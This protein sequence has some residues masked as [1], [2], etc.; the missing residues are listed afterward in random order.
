MNKKLKGWEKN[1]VLTNAKRC[2]QIKQS[3][4]KAKAEL[5]E[6]I[7]KAQSRYEEK[8]RNN[9]KV[10]AYDSYLDLI[11]RITRNPEIT[12]DDIYDVEKTDAVIMGNECKKTEYKLKDSFI[13]QYLTAEEAEKTETETTEET[14]EN[15]I[16]DQTETEEN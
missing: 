8:M 6:Q 12:P 16:F 7:K 5:D 2:L 13:A 1:Q 3:V 11:R 14:E 10:A 4:D 15:S 9:T